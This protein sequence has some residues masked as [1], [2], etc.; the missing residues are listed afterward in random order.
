[1]P[2]R[3]SNENKFNPYPN[4]RMPC[5]GTLSRWPHGF[6]YWG[7]FIYMKRSKPTKDYSFEYIFRQKTEKKLPF[8]TYKELIKRPECFTFS[9][10][11]ILEE[12][13]RMV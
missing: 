12:Y 9:I 13:G 10:K 1:M 11:H 8:Y 5:A 2:K 7:Y 6:F 3:E 4:N